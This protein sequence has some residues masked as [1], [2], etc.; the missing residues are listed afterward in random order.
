MKITLTPKAEAFIKRMIRLG[1][2]GRPDA[3]MRLTISPGGCSGLATEFSIELAPREGDVLWEEKGCRLFLPSESQPLLREAILHFVE[4][5][6]ET[7]LIVLSG[8]AGSCS[9]S[10]AAVSAGDGPSAEKG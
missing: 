5:P 9:C 3:G 6:M 1:S 7:R 2:G 8:P 10:Q 4:N